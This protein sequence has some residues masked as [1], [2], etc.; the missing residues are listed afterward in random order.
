MSRDSL[1]DNGAIGM[2]L[3]FHS[4]PPSTKRILQRKIGG[5]YSSATAGHES[6]SYR[7]ENGFPAVFRSAQE[8]L[9]WTVRTASSWVGFLEFYQWQALRD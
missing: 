6:E 2:F 8:T 3:A 5:F 9:R 7:C 4:L 1:Q